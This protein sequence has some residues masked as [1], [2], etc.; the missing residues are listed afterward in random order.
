MINTDRL[1]LRNWTSSDRDKFVALNQDPDVMAYFP[2]IWSEQ[3]SKE[4][5][6]F[7][8]ERIETRGWGWWAVEETATAEF[9]GFI[10]LN[11]IPSELP[12]DCNY[13][14]GWRLAKPYWGRGYATEAATAALQYAFTILNLHEIVAF[15]T[16]ENQRSRRVMENL[17]M[18]NL[19]QNFLHPNVSADS[20]LQEH[21]L[22]GML[23][24]TFI[25]AQ[26]E[27]L[28]D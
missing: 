18:H 21:V 9:I 16:V 4:F 12:I 6:D 25:N 11:S 1:I 17:G 19:E 15:T 20:G 14:I 2:E 24:S 13:E 22:Y 23:R 3:R 8:V 7:C 28:F 5:I 26:A 27:A 10:G